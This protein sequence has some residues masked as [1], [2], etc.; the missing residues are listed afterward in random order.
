MGNANA[1]WFAR[2][3]PRLRSEDLQLSVALLTVQLDWIF[4][5]W[6]WQLQLFFLTIVNQRKSVRLVRTR[7][8]YIYYNGYI[9]TLYI[10]TFFFPLSLSL[11]LLLA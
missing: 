11:S 8:R 6:L 2:L 10:I 5:Y 9:L 4:I 3:T 7:F 1:S